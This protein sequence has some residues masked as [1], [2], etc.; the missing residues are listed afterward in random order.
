MGILSDKKIGIA[1][2]G[3][4]IRAI[5]FHAGVVK[6][7]AE[8]NL[9]RKVT[10]ISSVSG[11][12]LFTGLVFHLSGNIWPKAPQ[13]TEKILP[14]LRYLMT[15]TSLQQ[16]SMSALIKPSNWKNILYKRGIVISQTIESLWGIDSV[17][18]D[19]PQTPVWTI[20]GTNGENG[21]RFRF[22]N[23]TMGDYRT[24]YASARMFKTAKAMAISAA[25]P[26]GIGPIEIDTSRYRWEKETFKGSGIK[27]RVKPEYKKLHIYD[28]GLYDNLGTETFYKVGEQDVQLNTKD[29]DFVIISDAGSPFIE[30]PL[31]DGFSL[32][33]ANKLIDILLEQSRLL[34]VRSFMNFLRNNGNSGV[35]LSLSDSA[36]LL[37]PSK[38]DDLT[39]SEVTAARQL[40]TSLDQMTGF[41]FDSL[42]KCGYHAAALN[43]EKY[44]NGN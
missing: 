27:E 18:A 22:K 28:G 4:G 14:R 23:E 42:V 35:Y 3:G 34:R 38:A 29:V 32:S 12:S 8:H 9:M 1:L 5:A 19:L 7:L 13:F 10:N 31:S 36:V 2:S 40:P 24:G 30:T 41:E 6:F 15:A 11:G 39:V 33:K 21:Q 25:F 17:L 16:A 37:Y 44:L 20:N 43:I 26:I